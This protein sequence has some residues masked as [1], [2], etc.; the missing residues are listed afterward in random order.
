MTNTPGLTTVYEGYTK[1]KAVP[2]G[3]QLRLQCQ[4]ESAKCDVRWIS[5]FGFIV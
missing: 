4:I 3:W 5:H 1:Q 2:A